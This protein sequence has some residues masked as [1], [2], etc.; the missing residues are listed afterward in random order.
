MK[1][2]TQQKQKAPRP[3]SKAMQPHGLAHASQMPPL[4]GL[5]SSHTRKGVWLGVHYLG[6]ACPSAPTS[7][8]FS[9]QARLKNCAP[10]KGAS[11]QHPVGP[12]VL[13]VSTVAYMDLPTIPNP[14]SAGQWL[15]DKLGAAKP[16]AERGAIT[17]RPWAE[18]PSTP[19]AGED[20][21]R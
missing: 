5:Y 1:Q 10:E 17:S 8:C 4:F 9:C 15:W 18:L 6:S 13:K 19:T 2:R 20:A 16:T 11:A 12:M 21:W 7:A 14:N 3:T